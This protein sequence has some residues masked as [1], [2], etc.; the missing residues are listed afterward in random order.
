MDRE[1]LPNLLIVLL[2]STG[3]DIQSGEAVAIKLEQDGNWAE[4]LENEAYVYNEN[5]SGG[6]GIPRVRWFGQ[7]SNFNVMISDLLGPSLEDL[8]AYCEWK[9]SLKTVLLLADQ[10]ICRMRYIHSK[11]I[12]HGD[13]KP[14]NHLMGTGKQGSIVY[15][16]DFGLARE[17]YGEGRRSK[18]K[19]KKVGGNHIRRR[20]V[21][22]PFYASIQHHQDHGKRCFLLTALSVCHVLM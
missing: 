14:G 6:V 5:L 8:F 10:L 18:K 15:T 19:K 17:F 2:V 21:G 22:T 12:L 11:S 16:I 3:T 4:P 20:M 13:I 7:E 9:F 1:V